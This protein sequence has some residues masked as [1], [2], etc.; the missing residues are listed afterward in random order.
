MLEKEQDGD[1][2]QHSSVN[3][4]TIEA[5]KFNFASPSQNMN[6]NESSSG[7]LINISR[8]QIINIYKQKYN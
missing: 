5:I 2:W 4:P 7:G 1:M 3:E 8:D 6:H